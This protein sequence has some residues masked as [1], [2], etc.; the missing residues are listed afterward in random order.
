[1]P[2]PAGLRFGK[3][4]TGEVIRRLAT[5]DGASDCRFLIPVLTFQ[6]SIPGGE[7]P[8]KLIGDSPSSAV[9]CWNTMKITC[10]AFQGVTGDYDLVIYIERALIY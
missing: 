5:A 4:R 9:M 2:R 8:K 3:N 1:M 6:H 7:G 10:N